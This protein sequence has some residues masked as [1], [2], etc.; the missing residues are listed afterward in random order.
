MWRQL[1]RVG[2]GGKI[3]GEL[4]S[5]RLAMRP[6]KRPY[7]DLPAAAFGPV[8][9]KPVRAEMI[10]TEY[11]GR[12]RS[13][14][15]VDRQVRRIKAVFKWAVEPELLPPMVHHGLPAAAGIRGGPIRRE[16][17]RQAMLPEVRDLE[18]LS[19]GEVLAADCY[20][21]SGIRWKRR[22]VAKWSKSKQKGERRQR[23]VV[24]SLR[25][26]AGRVR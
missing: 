18:W 16:R 12:R 1:S 21:S 15:Y 14:R 3:S 24:R 10:R 11:R 4:D 9:L 22:A 19:D 6:I 23:E 17:D 5:Y 13:P 26:H 8:T 7:T 25:K 20:G 2:A